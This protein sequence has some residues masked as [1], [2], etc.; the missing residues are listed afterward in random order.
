MNKKLLI[1]LILIFASCA[2]LWWW[3]AADKNPVNMIPAKS[4]TVVRLS[5]ET[6]AQPLVAHNLTSLTGFPEIKNGDKDTYFFI[7][8]NEYFGAV[9]TLEN[10][11]EFDTDLPKNVTHTEENG[12]HWYWTEA[13]WLAARKGKTLLLLGPGTV[14]ERDRLR[15]TLAVMLE[16]P[17]NE[18]FG[19]SDRAKA[20]QTDAPIA[21]VANSDVLPAPYG[22][23]LRLGLPETSAPISGEA[24]LSKGIFELKGG[25][26]NR[27]RK[28]VMQ[29]GTQATH[30]FQAALV[31]EGSELLKRLRGDGTLRMLL[32]ALSDS[33]SAA[34]DIKRMCGTVELL[35]TKLDTLGNPTF[36]LS[37][38]DNTGKPI[39]LQSRQAPEAATTLEL[40]PNTAAHA[41]ID[42]RALLASPLPEGI[43]EVLQTIFGNYRQAEL[44][45][46]RQGD[47]RLSFTP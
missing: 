37:G 45:T 5:A 29:T 34:N 13:G 16:A 7:T 4:K 19:H 36:R 41:I 3:L 28:N 31:A 43:R 24:T 39:V 18:G 2:T 17:E 27:P 23:L 38:T 32:T 35:I 15:H 8:P 40:N 11:S 10:A 20:L 12:A 33:T 22:T 42:I 26:S 1:S 44:T 25:I 9:L 6:F 47:F 14:Q 21:F 46:T 30:L